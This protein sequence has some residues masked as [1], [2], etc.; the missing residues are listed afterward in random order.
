LNESGFGIADVPA[1]EA[2]EITTA[3]RAVRI[4]AGD[5]P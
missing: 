4:C 1:A 2:A 3:L 5:L